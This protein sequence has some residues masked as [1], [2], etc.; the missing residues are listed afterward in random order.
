MKKITLI[1]SFLS[2]LFTAWSQDKLPNF[3]KIDKADLEMTDCSF[4][5]GAEAF[6]LIDLGDISFSYIQNVGWLSESNY[7]I[8]IKVLKEK[9]VNRA[10][11]KLHYRSKNKLEDIVNVKGV[12]FNLN[13]DGTVEESE[14]EKKS[15]YEKAI[16][17]DISEISFALPNVKAG[18]VFEYRY[19]LIRRSYSH[20]PSWNFQQNI[21]VR[22]SAYNAV[23]PEYFQFT[24]LS[25][26]RQKMEREDKNASENGSWYIM[27]NIPGLKD[28]PYS[29]GRDDNLQR[30][31]FQLSA[32]N[33]PNYI[34]TIRT[35][36]PKIIE[37]LLEAEEFGRAI[38]KNIKGTSDLDAQINYSQT[39]KEK[40]RLIYNYV[41]RNM[42]W[43][44]RYGIV[45]YNGIKEAWDKK[46]G[47]ITEINFILI[48]LLKE[49]GI[50]A[51]PL[52]VSTK[53]NGKVNAFYPF[54]NQFNGVMAYVKDG[55]DVY[56]MNAADKFNPFNLV[57]YDVAFTNALIVDKNETGVTEVYSDDKFVNNVF[58]TC[59]VKPD[60]KL[61]GQ[62]TL[63]SSGY[64]RNI[65]MQTISKKRLKE[66]FEDN[67]GINIKA[68][69]VNVNNA[70]NE[71]LPLEQKAEF[72]GY[73]QAGGEYQ[74]LPYNLFTGMGKN[75][76]IAENRV[77]DIDFS[78]PKT[79]VVSGTYYLPDDFI[80][81]ELPKNTKMIMPDTS[82]VLTRLMQKDG[83]NISFRFT[84]DIKVMGYSAESY[85][86]IKEYFKKMY[87]ILD[88]RIVLKKK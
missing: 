6:V 41:Q 78:F 50:K 61:S 5:P 59:N 23:V 3:G 79:Y 72:S 85:P 87:A 24:V 77:M 70:D 62:A 1:L 49:A 60:G 12:S 35:T 33:A 67:A 56:I 18:S 40:I 16:D 54:L 82:I 45:T 55:E 36:W 51:Q 83:N 52:L 39:T 14:L 17:N 7:R 81:N 69:T 15:I 28:E 48:N 80:I 88:E 31:D 58:F 10:Q 65:R 57:P 26:L 9:G 21:P 86:Y 73:M 66:I 37:E 47:S 30:V 74:F 46:N 29:S 84:L 27:H 32:I 38:K 44:E 63:T 11:I 20:I 76:F 19:K 68:D 53:D 43:N 4:D 13:A 42:Q 22:Y 64:A 8:R 25:T 75:P 71:L 2:F 34:E